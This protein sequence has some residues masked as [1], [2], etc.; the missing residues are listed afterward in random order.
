MFA[1]LHEL[2]MLRVIL[3]FVLRPFRL[4][5]EIQ[6]DLVTLIDHRAVASRHFPGVE[7]H[8]AWNGRKVFFGVRDDFVRGVWLGGIS[9]KDDDMR[10]HLLIYEGFSKVAQSVNSRSRGRQETGL[11]WFF[12]PEGQPIVAW[13]E[14][15]GTATLESTVP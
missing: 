9:P 6:G 11:G 15:P 3:I 7:A 1:L 12:I 5:V 10:K 14:V 8:H 2:E 4:K 13:H